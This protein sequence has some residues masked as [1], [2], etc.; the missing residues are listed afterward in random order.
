MNDSDSILLSVKKLL[1]I[2]QEMS[3][4]DQDIIININSAISVLTQLG[5]GPKSGFSIV[6]D[7]KTFSDLLGDDL[8]DEN[9][10]KMYLYYKVRLGFD[11]PSSSILIENMKS[12]ISE[13]EWRIRE[14]IEFFKKEDFQN[15]Q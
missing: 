4:F 9:L 14:Q 10:A 3:A 11:P 1:G 2:N 5:V 8:V 7:T 12:E 13:I 6:D 15:E